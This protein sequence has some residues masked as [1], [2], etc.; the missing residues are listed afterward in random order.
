VSLFP[1]LLEASQRHRMKGKSNFYA[2]SCQA[3]NKRA[4]ATG[5]SALGVCTAS[6]PETSEHIV[7]PWVT[8]LGREDL[9][10]VL[11]SNQGFLE[12]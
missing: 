5:A 3:V 10:A 4:E 11:G 1:S 9:L 2:L 6:A 12:A 7:A 8:V